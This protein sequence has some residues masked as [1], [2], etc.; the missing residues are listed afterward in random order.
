MDQVKPVK[1][2]PCDLIWL[3]LFS[4]LFWSPL[5]FFRDVMWRSMSTNFFLLMRKWE[6]ESQTRNFGIRP[7]AWRLVLKYFNVHQHYFF[8]MVCYH[9]IL[10]LSYKSSCRVKN[11]CDMWK[12]YPNHCCLYIITHIQLRN[13]LN[14][15]VHLINNWPKTIIWLGL[16]S[17]GLRAATVTKQRAKAFAIKR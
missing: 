12:M 5:F 7:S 1:L 3:K 2:I 10:W 13:S 8:T 9:V 16:R 15:L 4:L 14:P 11:F 6:G 17:Q